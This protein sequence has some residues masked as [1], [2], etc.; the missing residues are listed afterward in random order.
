MRV[1][2]DRQSSFYKGIYSQRP[3]TERINSQSKE[4]GIKRLHE[5]Y[6]SLQ[7]FNRS[8]AMWPTSTGQRVVGH[9]NLPGSHFC[10]RVPRSSIITCLR[11]AYQSCITYS[12]A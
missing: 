3:N 9:G 12:C 1:T 5:T 2:L 7:Y 10:E 4:L 8:S 6:T 11:R